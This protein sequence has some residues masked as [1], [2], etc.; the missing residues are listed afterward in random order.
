MLMLTQRLASVPST[1]RPAPRRSFAFGEW[2][3]DLPDLNHP[4]V[5]EA[6]NVWPHIGGYK[7]WPQLAA[8]SDAIDARCQGAFSGR[9]KD[10]D[11][12]RYAGDASK[13]YRLV[14][15]TQTDASKVGGYTIGE[16]DFWEFTRWGNQVFATNIAD[17]VQEITMA[18]TQFADLITSTLKPQAKHIAV[19]RNFLV[20]AHTEE[21]G[22]RYPNRVRWSAIE[23]P[24]DFDADI[25]TQSDFQDLE[26]SSPRAG[27]I[28]GIVGREYG[29]IFQENAIW[30]MSYIGTPAIFQFDEIE[31]GRG[32]YIKGSIVPFGRM[33]FFCADDGFYMTDGAQTVPIGRNKIDR[34]FFNDLSET[35]KDRMTGVV[36]SQDSVVLWSYVSKSNSGGVPD[37]VLAYNW[38]TGAWS[39]GE[40]DTQY[41]FNATTDGYT[42]DTLDGISTDLDALQFSLDSRAWT[43]GASQVSAYNSSNQLAHF[44]GVNAYDATV[45]G[46]E[47]EFSPGSHSLP[48][49]LR[50]LV[51][52]ASATVTTQIGYRDA[53]TDA[54]TYST[55]RSPNARGEVPV[56]GDNLFARYHRA[57]INVTGNFEE[58]QGAEMEAAIKGWK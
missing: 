11:I 55:A 7:P 33:V 46:P 9:D 53:T 45:T 48:L 2:L 37:K 39:H 44:D 36:S 30:R 18:N 14:N 43:G 3:P 25:N 26:G 19:V 40:I 29:I 10:G 47:V 12:H 51:H 57:Q 15:T 1:N 56:R 27:W 38:V 28:Q 13:L 54:V 5:T 8:F 21:G 49:Y 58:I 23:D 35:F 20:L 50:P 42:L 34:Y 31:T 6:K 41:L 17:P 16:D 4:G 22:T 24:T 32:A 52:G